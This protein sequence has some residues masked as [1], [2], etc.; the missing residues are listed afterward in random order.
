MPPKNFWK[1]KIRAKCGK[2][3]GKVRAK[4]QANSGAWRGRNE[5]TEKHSGK[6]TGKERKMNDIF[7][8]ITLFESNSQE[9]AE[10]FSL[11]FSPNFTDSFCPNYTA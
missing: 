10:F 5:T 2:N 7:K 1:P 4:F 3:L 6:F 9:L 8:S 11:D